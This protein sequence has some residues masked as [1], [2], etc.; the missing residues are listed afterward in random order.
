MLES[1]N[2]GRTSRAYVD[3]VTALALI[4]FT[5]FGLN[6]DQPAEKA[7]AY[8]L[9]ARS[10]IVRSSRHPTRSRP[11]RDVTYRIETRTWSVALASIQ[12]LTLFASA[13]LVSL[14]T[15]S[16]NTITTFRPSITASITKHFPASEI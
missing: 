3:I 15:E 13:T 16:S 14:P 11:L 1:D 10:V 9:T 5:I 7:A 12:L 6:S 4:L 2:N 8:A